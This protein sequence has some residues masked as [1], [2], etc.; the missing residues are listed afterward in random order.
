MRAVRK[1]SDVVAEAEELSEPKFIHHA[2]T[3][4]ILSP[5]LGQTQFGIK[6]E[7]RQIFGARIRYRYRMK[8]DWSIKLIICPMNQEPKQTSV[9]LVP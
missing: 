9:P 6:S 3:A 8:H 2:D 4:D 5:D 7:Y 1:C